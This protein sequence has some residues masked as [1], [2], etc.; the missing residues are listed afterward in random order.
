MSRQDRDDRAERSNASNPPANAGG[1]ARTASDDE[2][3]PR[4]STGGASRAG[5]G[6]GDAVDPTVRAAD[7]PL[8]LDRETMRR[9]GYRVVDMLVDRI[10]DLGGEPAWKVES[11]AELERRLGE[12]PPAE[13]TSDFDGLLERLTT[14]VLPY[15]GRVDHPRFFAFIPSCPTW[16][17]LLGDFLA[18]GHSIFQGTWLESAGPSALELVVLGWFKEWIGYPDGAAGVLVSG[19]SAANLNALVCAREARLGAAT[20]DGVVYLSDQTHSSVER[21]ARIAGF[22]EERI[23][24]LPTRAYRLSPETL[25]AAVDE[26][27][28]AG[29]RPVLVVANAGST[30]TG[31]IDPLAELAD[32]CA[33]QDVWLHVDAAYGGYAVLTERGRAL[34][35]GIER[36]DSVTLDPHK[37]L[38]Q[39][40]EAGC[41]LVRRGELLDDAFHI[42]PDYLQDTETRQEEAGGDWRARGVNFADRGLQL[43]RS[44]R[45][46][47]IWLS[48]Q[49]FGVDR[50]RAVIDR[51]FDLAVHAQRRIEASSELE[52][53]APARLGIVCFRRRPSDWSDEVAAFGGPAADAAAGDAGGATEPEGRDG[54]RRHLEARLERV[55]ESLVERLSASG[56]GM[57]SSTRLDGR[58]ALRLC[59]LNHRSRAEDVDRV[60]EWLET[61]PIERT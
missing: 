15:A 30:N 22:P 39:P 13:P 10:S 5:P 31:T 38:Y 21:A 40:F 51:C 14:D 35:R 2:T 26:D 50:F 28:R 45:A 24:K 36:A 4:A 59:I 11:R 49:T 18:A 29:R 23:R 57:I 56:L 58:Y 47:K 54:R 32:V 25:R 1:S 7:D 34:L 19:G 27:R 42:M 3:R 9:L 53:L 43:T 37:W 61:A 52:L 44:S 16:P 8:E 60:L 20:D 48:L 33:E 17:G 41:L 55:N 12:P 46:L 6:A